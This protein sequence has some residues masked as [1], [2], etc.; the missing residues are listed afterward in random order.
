MDIAAA[1]ESIL[2]TYILILKL[3]FSS[4]AALNLAVDAM[5]EISAK[6]FNLFAYMFNEEMKTK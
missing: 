1:A 6:L 3:F 5:D 4:I 2:Y